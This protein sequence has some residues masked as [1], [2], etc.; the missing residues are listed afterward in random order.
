MNLKYYKAIEELCDEVRTK[1][2]LANEAL[3]REQLIKAFSQA[4]I[5]GDFQRLVT[6]DGSKQQVVIYI[7]YRGI[8]QL[9]EEV[10]NLKETLS[11]IREL[12][13]EQSNP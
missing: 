1:H 9:R 10:A 13:T 5:C 12:L 7:P 4:L 2:H 8:E 3:T 11:K 6:V